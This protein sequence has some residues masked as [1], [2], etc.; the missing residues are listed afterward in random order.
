MAAAVQ[1]VELSHDILQILFHNLMSQNIYEGEFNTVSPQSQLEKC[2][3][4]NKANKYC[5]TI[6]DG[7]KDFSCALCDFQSSRK[8]SLEKHAANAHGM[9]R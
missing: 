5:R 1:P 2:H 7:I 9:N 4:H 3:I 6:H 8:R